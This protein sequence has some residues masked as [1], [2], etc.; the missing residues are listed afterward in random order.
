MTN[1]LSHEKQ[2]QLRGLFADGK[3]IRQSTK[4]VGCAQGT[5]VLYHKKFRDDTMELDKKN[6]A[7]LTAADI[8]KR[9]PRYFDG[10]ELDNFRRWSPK[11]ITAVRALCAAGSDLDACGRTLGRRPSGIA[12]KA[13]EI[14]LF[15]PIAWSRRI[16]KYKPKAPFVPLLAFPY[17]VKQ[18]RPEHELILAVNKCVPRGLPEALREDVCQEIILGVLDGTIALETI[19][20]TL[21]SV[22]R[23]VRKDNSAP[24]GT[25]SFD[26]AP[27]WNDDGR[28][29]HETLSIDAA[30]VGWPA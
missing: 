2:K 7:V 26:A 16:S 3:T 13:R 5:A 10:F 9:P 27:V 20:Q 28:P 24:F 11:D 6:G 18:T 4:I 17:I 1:I 12:H 22:L 14:G 8:L 15:L 29:L 30:A 19:A 25:L 23:R 21:P